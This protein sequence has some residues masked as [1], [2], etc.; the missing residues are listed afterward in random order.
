M[1]TPD[2]RSEQEQ[3]DDLMK[4][5]MEKVNIDTKYKDEFEGLVS[6]IENRLQKLK[7][8]SAG[9]QEKVTTASD[10]D[11]QS[12]NEEKLLKKIIEEVRFKA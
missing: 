7:E 11:D 3:A 8:T 9:G 2:L 6:D 12:D 1:P 4:Q 10:S 5:Y